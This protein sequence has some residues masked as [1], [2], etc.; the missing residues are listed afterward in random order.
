MK[1]SSKEVPKGR[2]QLARS[3]R[4]NGTKSERLVWGCLCNR[5]LGVKFR[6]QVPVGPYIVDFLSIKIKTIVEIDGQQHGDEASQAKDAERDKY[7]REEGYEVV[8]FWSRD[9]TSNLEGCM[10]HLK[11]VVE[12]RQGSIPSPMGEGEDEGLKTYAAPLFSSHLT[13][14]KGEEKELRRRIRLRIHQ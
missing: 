10:Q 3:F 1:T 14:S 13:S 6:R 8:R 12:A 2:T 9:I 11:S 7:L 4:R 5:G